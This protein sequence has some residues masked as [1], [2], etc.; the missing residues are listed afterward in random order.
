MEV[1]DVCGKPKLSRSRL[2][3]DAVNIG[4]QVKVEMMNGN[5]MFDKSAS[6]RF[7]LCKEHATRATSVN[8]REVI[9]GILETP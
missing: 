2:T 5:I 3:L 8:W 9:K 4:E 1:C 6:V 7:D